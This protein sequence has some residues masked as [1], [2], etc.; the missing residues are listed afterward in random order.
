[1]YQRFSL[2]ND[3]SGVLEREIEKERLCCVPNPIELTK[4]QGFKASIC[5]LCCFFIV[6]VCLFFLDISNYLNRGLRDQ[7]FCERL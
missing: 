5:Q 4:R 6:V 3:R 1:M 7:E 2:G